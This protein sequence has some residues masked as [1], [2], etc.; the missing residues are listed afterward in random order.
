MVQTPSTEPFWSTLGARGPRARRLAIDDRLTE[1]FSAAQDAHGV[2][3]VSAADYFAYLA[4]RCGDADPLDVLGRVD[5]PELYLVLSCA[6][7]DDRALRRFE[8]HYFGEIARGASRLRCSP[9]EL[10]EV[11]QAV[12]HALFSPGDD[13]QA[14]LVHRTARGDLRALIRLIALRAGISARR[15]RGQPLAADGDALLE[16]VDAERSPSVMMVKREHQQRFRQALAAALATLEARPRTLLR[17]HEVDGVSQTRLAT[18]HRVDRST[19]T[20]WL[21]RA[22]AD[23]LAE[24]RRQLTAQ[25][26][27][28]HLDFDSF[29]D[30]IRSN[31]GASI[32]RLLASGEL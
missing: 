27:V 1:L 24:T 22:R 3:G 2:L 19:I 11:R 18:M 23:V 30:V 20:R 29:I 31:F 5:G 26:G 4:R 9:E 10:D 21:A 16:V 17:L 12:R 32:H 13:G 6:T 8:Q 28:A 25:Y 15:R 7:G 14:K